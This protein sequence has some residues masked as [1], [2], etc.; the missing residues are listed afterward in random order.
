MK[1]IVSQLK[2]RSLRAKVFR[3]ASLT[4][5]SHGFEQILRLGSSLILTRLLF[6]EVYGTMA[7]VFSVVMGLGMLS[8]VGIYSSLLQHKDAKEVKFRNS[9]WTLQI[10]RGFVIWVGTAS[11]AFPVSKFYGNENLFFVL[12]VYGF[13][14]FLRGFNSTS[15]LMNQR[16]LKQFKIT[17]LKLS[18]QI[19]NIIA[20]IVAAY[21]LRSEWAIV[22]GAYVSTISFLLLSHAHLNG[23]FKHR[24]TWHYE[25]IL[26]IV[27]LGKWLLLSSLLGFFAMQGDR[28][29]LGKLLSIEYLGYYALATTFASIP[30]QLQSSLF[31]TLLYPLYSQASREEAPLE[32][33]RQ[34][35]FKGRLLLA[36]LL[37]PVCFVLLFIGQ[38]AIGLLYD[39]RYFEAGYILQVLMIGVAIDIATNP[40]PLYL[41]LNKPKLNVLIN[42]LKMLILFSVI[43]VAHYFGGVGAIIY[44]ITL[45]PVFY[46]LLHIYF[47]QRLN[48]WMWKLDAVLVV[49]VGAV[50]ALSFRF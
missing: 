36:S 8:D 2:G 38:Y 3:V 40:G 29:V 18:G 31:M 50:I 21:F 37:L 1:N 7:L 17:V 47:S 30:G 35:V 46:F 24:L 15:V 10:L 22:I 27:S 44:G 19:I 13:V 32:A 28:F 6:P 34:K 9:A 43:Y 11:I 48:L 5:F 33:I 16:E 26:S 39:E 23:D 20:T 12:V 41:S 25:S 14:E 45:A 49:L 42:F 4:L